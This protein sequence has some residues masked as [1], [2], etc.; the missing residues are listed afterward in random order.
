MVN[1]VDQAKYGLSQIPKLVEK[2]KKLPEISKETYSELHTDYLVPLDIKIDCDSF[3]EEIEPYDQYLRPWGGMEKQ[4]SVELGGIPLVNMTGELTGIDRSMGSLSKWC[5]DHPDEPIIDTDFRTPTEILGIDSLK[6]LRVFDKYWT[7][8]SIL[9]WGKGAEFPPHVDTFV[10]AYWYR[11]WSPLSADI[12]VEFNTKN[13]FLKD[14][15]SVRVMNLEP[16]RIYLIDTSVVHYAQALANNV[17]QLFLSVDPG[18]TE[19]IK[20][21]INKHKDI[22]D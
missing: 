20:E 2:V 6:A 13:S 3:L 18:A 8:S 9:K 15:Y 14:Q 10:P 17:Y 21:L 11:L 1:L 22:K 16:G 12:L 4:S 7:K 5:L 19:L